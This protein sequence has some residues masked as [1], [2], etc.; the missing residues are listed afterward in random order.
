M[1]THK[2]SLRVDIYLICCVVTLMDIFCFIPLFFL[3]STC[4]YCEHIIEIWKWYM[5]NNLYLVYFIVAE[6]T[7]NSMKLKFHD[8]SHTEKGPVSD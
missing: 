6:D 3:P 2:M 8:S 1:P 4:T 5:L 7:I